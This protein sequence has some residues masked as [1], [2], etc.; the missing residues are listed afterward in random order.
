M[1]ARPVLVGYGAVVAV[2]VV[3]FARWYKEPTLARQFGARYD[4]YRHTV[5]G[6]IPR[7]PR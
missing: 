6:W 2:T 1:L 3:S 7:L 4:T 5:P